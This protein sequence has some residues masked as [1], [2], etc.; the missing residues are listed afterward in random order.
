MRVKFIAL[1]TNAKFI[2]CGTDSA[3]EVNDSD[4]HRRHKS[5][6]G[7]IRIQGPMGLWFIN[8]AASKLFSRSCV[9]AILF[10]DRVF[11]YG[12][13]RLKNKSRKPSS[14]N[15]GKCKEL[16]RWMEISTRKPL[17]SGKELI[18]I[19]EFLARFVREAD[20]KG[21]REAQAFSGHPPFLANFAQS[22]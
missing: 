12:L 15:T 6:G 13:Y 18:R 1:R 3:L 5:S 4:V 21:T 20:K 9:R 11:C 17:F 2:C 7:K 14:R 22:R 10:Y 8:W 19:L 16:I